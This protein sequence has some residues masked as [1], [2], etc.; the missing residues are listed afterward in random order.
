MHLTDRQLDRFFDLLDELIVFANE[1]LRLVDSL[2]LPIADRR[3]EMKAAYVCDALWSHSEVIEEYVRLNPHRR[4]AADLAAVSAWRDALKGQFTLVRFERGRAILMN[5]AGLF[6]VVGMDE[7]PEKALSQCPDMVAAT[8][9]PFEGLIVTDGLMYGDGIPFNDQETAQMEEMLE[10]L[11]P[12]GI[13]WDAE[14]LVKRARVYNDQLR[15]LEFDELMSSL[16]LEARQSRDGERIP[17]GFHRGVLAGLSPEE[18]E[19]RVE[20]YLDRFSDGS[21]YLFS[22]TL[23]AQVTQAEPSESLEE[24]LFACMRK[25]ELL[26]LCKLLELR[27]YSDKNKRQLAQ[28]LVEPLAAQRAALE[29]DLIACRQQTFDFFAG[30]VKGGG[31]RE[32]AVSDLA[33]ADMME[34]FHP[35][36][37]QFR[38]GEKVT[39]VI[40]VE[41]RAM[42]QAVDLD[43]LSYERMREDALLN[44]ADA[45]SVYYGLL[46]LREAYDLYR[47]AVVDAY[48]L[49]DFV[50]M[51]MREDSY[52]DADFVLARWM[53]DSYLMHFSISDAHLNETVMNRHHDEF[54]QHAPAILREGP[55]GP[56]LQRLYQN[57]ADD[58]VAERNDLEAYRKRIVANRRE[59]P[60]RPLDAA[61]ADGDVFEAFFAMPALVQLR[62]FYDAHV[63]DN[64][65]DYTYADR[66]VEDLVLHAINMGSVDAYLDHLEQRG[67][68]RCAE[69]DGLL[70]RLA[71]NAYGALPSWELNGWSPQEVLENMSGRKVFYNARGELLRPAPDDPCPCG[72][73]KAYS[74]CHGK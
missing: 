50:A 64:E 17:E 21:S 10:R 40:P 26:D 74:D 24:C 1:R 41:L 51:L 30:L 12:G 32:D 6:A 46:N 47:G 45:M 48:P 42:A 60:R 49:D 37:F 73:G 5:D 62:D 38:V 14:E 66:A 7:D 20:G 28:M 33:T 72:S 16:E 68:N 3:S 25:E 71:E 35:Y 65:D 69:D 59:V 23:K 52:D 56:T 15:E 39:S 63:P 27:G 55:D 31:R 34:Q 44:C 57:I 18:R 54:V 58:V 19:K 8:L 22:K 2:R 53:D 4:P 36:A 29:R 13:A 70:L 61:C 43:A 11:G 67:V 9:L